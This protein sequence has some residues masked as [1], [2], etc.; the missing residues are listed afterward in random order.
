MQQYRKLNI[1]LY[2]S[3]VYL[4]TFVNSRIP[5]D[6]F[7]EESGLQRHR[8]V[9]AV[10]ITNGANPD[11]LAE[12]DGFV[13]RGKIGALKDHWLFEPK[14]DHTD[15]SGRVYRRSNEEIETAFQNQTHYL[16]ASEQIRKPRYRRVSFNDPLWPNEWYLHKDAFPGLAYDI[17]VIPVWEKGIFGN[18]VNVGVVDDGI[19]G[20]H[21]DLKDQFVQETSYNFLSKN[22]DVFPH[23]PIDS[24]GTRCAGEI[25]ATPNNTICSVGVAFK[26]KV[27]ALKIIGDI[28]PNDAD[29]AAALTHRLDHHHIFSSSWG[30]KDDG[31]SLDGPGSLTQA[32]LEF[33]ATHGR[34]GKG[35]LYVFAGGNGGA[36][37]DNCNFDGYA[38][39]L[40]TIT[41]GGLSPVG[42]LPFYAEPCAA[43]LAMM[44]GGSDG[45]FISTTDMYSGCTTQHTGTSAAAPLVS[46][47]L[48]LL[49]ELRQDLSYRDVQ[50]LIVRS[51]LINDRGDEDWVPNRAGR[52]VN[53]KYGFG[54]MNTN[55]LLT[56]AESWELVPTPLLA[57]QTSKDTERY[58]IPIGS[59]QPLR[60][61]KIINSEIANTLAFIEQVQVEVKIKHPKRGSL[62]IRLLSPED[63]RSFSV[64]ATARPHDKKTSGFHNWKFSTVRHWDESPIGNWTLEIEDTRSADSGE[65]D[66]LPRLTPGYLEGWSIK[67]TGRCSDDDMYFDPV[68]NERK[69]SLQKT[70]LRGID[71][72]KEPRFNMFF[73]GMFTT[74]VLLFLVWNLRKW[75][76]TGR[77]TYKHLKPT[78]MESSLLLSAE[79]GEGEI[80]KKQSKSRDTLKK[81]EE[82]TNVTNSPPMKSVRHQNESNRI[83][84][85]SPTP[86]KFTVKHGSKNGL[87]TT[88]HNLIELDTETETENEEN[89]LSDP[90]FSN[91]QPCPRSSPLSLSHI[92]QGN[93]GNEAKKNDNQITILKNLAQSTTSN[94]QN[95]SSAQR[96]KGKY[97]N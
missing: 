93:P 97:E 41:I 14:E 65:G 42:N 36:R 76:N 85:R 1:I 84:Q 22:S 73:L 38:N 82:V 64:L 15:T 9:W 57:F 21:P 70:R 44:F 25:V 35:V 83:T 5:H 81:T 88:T 72:L 95:D 24:H 79:E 56:K 12:R 32:A 71:N 8:R 19:Q 30:P 80:E 4:L 68:T 53:H 11:T 47:I 29:E 49:L 37:G 69:C 54:L 55:L 43:H 17:G 66:T 7:D 26:A 28:F 92:Y 52:L 45:K 20:D 91:Q 60:V 51:T 50:H 40:Y 67:F 59:G 63:G 33:G 2:I 77:F 6:E 90:L 78:H 96:D 58:T 61:T 75:W 34:G 86:T 74:W 62:V 31:A 94:H 39:S 13:N 23:Q 87:M 18:G 3:F 10:K 89:K 16:W 46:G 48:A 27:S